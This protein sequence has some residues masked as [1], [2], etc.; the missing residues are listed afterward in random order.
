MISGAL[1]F[2]GLTLHRPQASVDLT[3]IYHNIR[4][5]HR[6]KRPQRVSEASG[7][8]HTPFCAHIEKKRP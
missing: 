5:P 8:K 3:T 2:L 4:W 1:F 6:L 7:L